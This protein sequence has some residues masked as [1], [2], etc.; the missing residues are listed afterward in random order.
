[1][2]LVLLLQNNKITPSASYRETK[3]EKQEFGYIF[4]LFP[5]SGKI[6]ALSII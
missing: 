3:A 1:M 2:V 6:I 4:W 5:K